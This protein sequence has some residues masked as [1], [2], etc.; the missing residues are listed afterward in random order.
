MKQELQ[1]TVNQHTNIKV[2][3]E[4]VGKDLSISMAV[5]TKRSIIGWSLR[6][7]L[8]LRLKQLLYANGYLGMERN[9]SIFK[10]PPVSDIK[11]NLEILMSM[12]GLMIVLSVIQSYL[13]VGFT[14]IHGKVFSKD[15]NQF[16]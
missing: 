11:Y 2:E 4:A 1:E 16:C 3:K 13:I 6:S 10:R 12:I 8:K 7:I 9:Y 5:C 15:Q 14:V